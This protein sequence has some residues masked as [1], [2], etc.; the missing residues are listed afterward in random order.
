MEQHEN[1]LTAEHTDLQE[2]DDSFTVTISPNMISATNQDIP[3]NINKP[4]NE[5][6]DGEIVDEKGPM[7]R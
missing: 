6:E 7:F 1:S 4:A 3:S 5:E 2:E